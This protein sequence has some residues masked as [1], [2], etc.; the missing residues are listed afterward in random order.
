MKFSREKI[1]ETLKFL[2]KG[3]KLKGERWKKEGIRGAYQW[4]MIVQRY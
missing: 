4:Q 3:E 2:E 1:D